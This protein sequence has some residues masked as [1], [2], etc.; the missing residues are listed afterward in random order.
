MSAQDREASMVEPR[1]LAVER[2]AVGLVGVLMLDT[3]FQRFPRDIGHPASLPF[4]TLQ[5]RVPKAYVQDVV[6]DAPLSPEVL[7]AF[8]AAG[9]ELVHAG[10]S[11]LTTSCGFLHVAQQ[12]LAQALGVP[13]VTSSLLALPLLQAVHGPDADLGVLTF[14]AEA[15]GSRHLGNLARKPCVVGVDPTSHF[16]DVIFERAEADPARLEHDVGQAAHVMALQRPAAV[17][18][19]CTNLAPW[20]HVVEQVC[21][22]PVVDLVDVLSWMLSRQT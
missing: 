7:D 11:V 6:T 9:H 18:L 8:L 21:D 10:A 22:V 3:H 13:V 15:L 19:E 17:V 16:S 1:A 4:A 5:K 20:R 2:R 12:K 14:D